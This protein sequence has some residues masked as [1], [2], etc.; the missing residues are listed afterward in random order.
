MYTRHYRQHQRHHH[1]HHHTTIIDF[2]SHLQNIKQQQLKS[3]QN[4]HFAHTYNHT[5][6]TLKVQ[7]R[8]L[9]FNCN[10]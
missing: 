7:F 1:H 3:S 6:H 9:L 8:L 4:K 10:I 2:C 5:A